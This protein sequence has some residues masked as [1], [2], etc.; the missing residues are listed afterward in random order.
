M[1]FSRIIEDLCHLHPSFI[2]LSERLEYAGKYS[3]SL[4]AV[5]EWE[6]RIWVAERKVL[7]LISALDSG[8]VLT[9]VFVWAGSCPFG[10]LP[11]RGF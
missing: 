5:V 8:S 11:A 1:G 7:G 4:G 6:V 3:G 2:D 9:S 10:E